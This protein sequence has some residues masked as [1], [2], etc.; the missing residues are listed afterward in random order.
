MVEQ[1]G[2]ASSEEE[3]VIV[4]PYISTFASPS[5]LSLLRKLGVFPLLKRQTIR[6]TQYTGVYHEHTVFSLT[7]YCYRAK[8]DIHGITSVWIGEVFPGT[9]RNPRTGRH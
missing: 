5:T 7:R 9:Y 4:Y 2:E 6:M 1:G 8:D 3:G